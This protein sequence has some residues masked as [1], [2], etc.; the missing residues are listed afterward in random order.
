MA[1]RAAGGERPPP[2][3]HTLALIAARGGSEGIP[4]KNLVD[5]CGK[6][7]LAW[8]IEQAQQADGIDLVAVSSDS[9]EIL[10]A[11]QR[12]GACPVKRPAEISGATAPSEAAWRHALD[13][14]DDPGKPF[15]RLVALQATSP[16]REPCDLTAAL[17]QYERDRLDSLLSVVE[18]RDYFNWR[19]GAGGRP[20]AVNYDYT[21]R[22]MRQAIERRYLE[23]GS[24]YIFK[25]WLLRENNNR[26]GGSIG[27][28]VMERHK[29]IQIDEPEDLFLC[30]L[31]MRG[32]GY[33]RA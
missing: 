19:I 20:E 1:P 12:F 6:P 17:A 10:A 23:N 32:Y 11:A 8:T 5:L 22:R 15:T 18:V 29:L 28:F 14:L 9:D 26:L 24:F 21:T 13:A 25:P 4:R 16:V 33:A 7:L 27:L 3:P 30:A 31:I 2:S